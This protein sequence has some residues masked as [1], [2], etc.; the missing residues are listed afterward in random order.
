MPRIVWHG[1]QS[2]AARH[3]PSSNVHE[4]PSALED[5]KAFLRE[6]LEH[7]A[8]EVTHLFSD[9][10]NSKI[11]LST[12]RRAKTALNIKAVRDGFGDEGAWF[13]KLSPEG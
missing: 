13:W 5:A 8:Q 11:S 2:Q 9:A 7:G 4:R 12:L 1:E 3:S 6:S 10:H